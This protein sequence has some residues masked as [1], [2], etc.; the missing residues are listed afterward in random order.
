MFF[1]RSPVGVVL[2]R[3]DVDGEPVEYVV[4]PGSPAVTISGDAP[5][6]VLRAFG[7]TESRVQITGDEE[8]LAAFAAS[9][10]GL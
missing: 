4:R 7:R 10:L 2:R 5:E 3:T 9:K 1:A 8:T 6:L